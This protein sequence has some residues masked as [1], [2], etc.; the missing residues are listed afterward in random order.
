MRDLKEIQK[1]QEELNRKDK[2][3]SVGQLAAGIAHEIRNPLSSIKG[4]ARILKKMP[5]KAVKKKRL[6]KS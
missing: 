3:A 5:K 6:R 2:L 1:L 4:F